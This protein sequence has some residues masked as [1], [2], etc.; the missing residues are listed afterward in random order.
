[1]STEIIY[2]GSRIHDDFFPLYKQIDFRFNVVIKPLFP[3]NYIESRINV[4]LL[5]EPVSD[6]TRIY[7]ITNLTFSSNECVSG[8]SL[9]NCDYDIMTY[10]TFKE[11]LPLYMKNDNNPPFNDFK[12][13]MR[14][15]CCS[16]WNKMDEHGESFG[17]YWRFSEGSPEKTN[18]FEMSFEKNCEC[19][20]KLNKSKEFLFETIRIGCRNRMESVRYSNFLIVFMEGKIKAMKQMIK[21]MNRTIV[22][23]LRQKIAKPYRI[24]MG[25]ID[26]FEEV[27]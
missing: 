11:L 1:M 19:M 24:V 6:F 18:A 23:I 7:D 25:Y 15:V 16:D 8:Y 5:E 26:L 20:Y 9:Y 13:Q 14:D 10:E 3:W 2:I 27:K 21:E 22:I 17:G 4:P 12:Q